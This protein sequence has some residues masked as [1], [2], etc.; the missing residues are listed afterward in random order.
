[1]IQQHQLLRAAF[2][3][4]VLLAFLLLQAAHADPYTLG[5]GDT[6]KIHVFQEP[7]LS[8]EA[9]ISNN[10]TVDFPLIGNIEIAG[11]SL[12]ETEAVLDRKLRGDYLIDPQISVS[13]ISHRPFFITGA[14]RS[15]G[16]YEYQPGMS[17]RQ[18]IAVAGDFT[19]RASRSKIYI[20]KESESSENSR[21]IKLDEPVGPGDTITVKESLF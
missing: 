19:E 16:S 14:V 12:A 7:D 1:M 8:I 17:V 20:I 6:I 11:L 10:G 5:S 4:L 21:K 3:C 13:V 18:A 15:P 2:Y 9:K